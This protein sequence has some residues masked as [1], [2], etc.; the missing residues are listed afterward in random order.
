MDQAVQHTKE[1][2]DMTWQEESKSYDHGLY[3]AAADLECALLNECPL[4]RCYDDRI[5]RR[6]VGPGK[7]RCPY[8]P[9]GSSWADADV[10]GPLWVKHYNMRKK[11]GDTT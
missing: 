11:G 7:F 6:A 2:D 3:A 10:C 9:G 4:G 1:E 8:M 5:L